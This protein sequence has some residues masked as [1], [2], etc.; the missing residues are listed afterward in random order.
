MHSS[1]RKTL[2]TANN[3]LWNCASYEVGARVP[4]RLA[5]AIGLAV[6]IG[7]IVIER[8]IGR[9]AVY[10]VDVKNSGCSDA[11]GF[12]SEAKPY[13]TLRYVSTIAVPGDTFL[14]QNG[15]YSQGPTAFT[16][17]GTATAPITYRVVGDAVFATEV[18]DENFQPVAGMAHVYSLPWTTSV[19]QVFQR[20][21]API[22]VDDPNQSVFTMVQEDGPLRL[23]PAPD[24]ATLIAQEGMWRISGGILFVHAYGDRRPSTA[25]T[26]FMLGVSGVQGITV[27]AK[28]QYNIFD[29]F[30]IFSSFNI[31]GVE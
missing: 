18:I 24:D 16:R 14:I 15:T 23:S 30:T 13:C 5:L 7:A 6:T 2:L 10:Y 12:G 17:S 25:G 29:G 1:L 28:T 21:F 20:R 4:I 27:D 8:P 19:A 26:D 3:A 9:A 31:S 11:T 22:L